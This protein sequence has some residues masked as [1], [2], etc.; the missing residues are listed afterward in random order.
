M[1]RVRDSAL[2]RMSHAPL[3]MDCAVL[4]RPIMNIGGTNMALAVQNATGSAAAAAAGVSHGGRVNANGAV[5]AAAGAAAGPR[6]V[7]G[8]T[9]ANLLQTDSQNG[10]TTFELLTIGDDGGNLMLFYFTS[11]A[12]QLCDGSCIRNSHDT[13][14]SGPAPAMGGDHS[15]CRAGG[16]G[17]G[18]SVAGAAW[19]VEMVCWPKVHSDWI[20]GLRYC[21]PLD[22]LITCSLDRTIKFI[23]VERHAKVSVKRVYHGHIKGVY[24]FAFSA[25]NKF[26]VSCG[27]EREVML[28]D[29]YTCKTVSMLYGHTTA[30]QRVLIDD[31][32]NI[33]VTLSSDKT[34]KTWD[35]R[36]LRTMQTVH[37]GQLHRPEDRITCLLY[38]SKRC[39][40]VTAATSIEYWDARGESK[41]TQVNRTHRTG[42]CAA[43]YNSNFQQVVSADYGGSADDDC[44]S[45]PDA[46]ATGSSSGTSTSSSSGGSSQD[47]SSSRSGRGGDESSTD[48]SVVCVWDVATGRNVFS[49]QSVSLKVQH[50]DDSSLNVSLLLL[51]QHCKVT[52][53]CF[54]SAGRRLI[55]GTDDGSLKMWNF[56]NGACLTTV[57]ALF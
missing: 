20:T 8:D 41:T 29:P 5:G 36:T 6:G 11:P 14:T 24:S 16:T 45:K 18:N 17:T 51:V 56:S 43:L 22:S 4:T 13:A 19:G 37:D 50:L 28:W 35:T 53:M 10:T 21:D 44:G 46:G 32:R 39:R 49:F 52:A 2:V 42:V 38:D 1:S 54:D 57:R 40:L 31:D 55:T 48:C 7:S 15:L 30:V 26:M 12:W 9:Q 27:A 47:A 34:I 3:C 25:A 23:D 33:M